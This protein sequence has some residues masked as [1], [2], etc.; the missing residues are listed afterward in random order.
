MDAIWVA[1]ATLL[2]IALTTLGY[3]TARP[4]ATTTEL[5]WCERIAALALVFAAAF[6]IGVSIR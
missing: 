5:R 3:S 6:L 2:A 4:G 1:W